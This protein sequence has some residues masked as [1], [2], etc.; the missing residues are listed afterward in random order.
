M[1]KLLITLSLLMANNAYADTCIPKPDCAAMGYTATSCSG[2]SLK[3]PFDTSKMFCTANLPS[4]V[5]CDVGMIYYSN[6]KCYSEYS[7]SYGVPLGVVVVADTLVMSN[8][9]QY[10]S[11]WT[12]ITLNTYHSS[13][14]SCNTN[15]S[16]SNILDIPT[17]SNL[18]VSKTDMAGKSNTTKIVSY[19]ENLENT[20]NAKY[21][22][23]GCTGIS[24]SVDYSSAAAYCNDYVTTGTSAGQWYLP[25]SGELY[26]YVLGGWDKIYPSLQ[27]FGTDFSSTKMLLSSTEASSDYAVGFVINNSDV[28]TQNKTSSSSSNYVTCFLEI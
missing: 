23:A 18:G 9:G 14:Y 6:G 27:K 19:L 16:L 12:K 2:G 26:S 10:V 7:T 22:A 20:I 17:L 4:A 11:G 28:Y 24:V 13:G 3:C 25:A 1:R 15:V 21:T 8:P 5:E